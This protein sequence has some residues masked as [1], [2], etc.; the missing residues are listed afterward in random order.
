MYTGK[1]I[2]INEGKGIARCVMGNGDFSWLPI[3]YIH[4]WVAPTD[5]DFV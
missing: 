2:E 5:S 1:V 4:K 3:E